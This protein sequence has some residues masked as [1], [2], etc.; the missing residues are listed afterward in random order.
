MKKSLSIAS[1]FLISVCISCHQVSS[2]NTNNDE[3][4]KELAKF[5]DNIKAVDNHAHPNSIEADDKDADALPLD[6]LGNIQL[7]ARLQPQSPDWLPAWRSV[8]GYKGDTTSE[9]VVRQMADTEMNL[10]KQK[11]E[12]FPAWVLD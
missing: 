6:G 2:S 12:N 5:I 7:P 1:L 9:Q 8:Y 10:I 4:D 11:G 3:P